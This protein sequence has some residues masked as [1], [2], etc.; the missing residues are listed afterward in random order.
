MTGSVTTIT[1]AKLDE[2]Y[3]TNIMN[4]LEGRV[5][6]LSTYNG[7]MTIRGTSSLYAETT[8]LLVVDGVPVEETS[9]I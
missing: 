8:P 5:A 6:G 4:N 1:S 7:K 9:T 2:R 3:T